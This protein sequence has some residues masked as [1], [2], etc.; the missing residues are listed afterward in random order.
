MADA[1]KKAG[2]TLEEEMAH[3]AQLNPTGRFGQ[4]EEFGQACAFLCSAHA[5][6][7]VGQN[8]LLDG[9]AFTATMG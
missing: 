1:A 8:L 3:R 2:R 9:G 6:Y 7:I 5:G 4:P